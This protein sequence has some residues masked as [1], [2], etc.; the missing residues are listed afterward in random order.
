MKYIMLFILVGCSST[1]RNFDKHLEGKTFHDRDRYLY[2][3]SNLVFRAEEMSNG[4]FVKCKENPDRVVIFNNKFLIFND[5]KNSA[6]KSCF[7]EGF[8]DGKVVIE[9]NNI[10]ALNEK[11]KELK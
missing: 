3:K 5:Y 9:A 10:N 7:N 1:Q 2:Y 11:I 6:I 8:V 4:I